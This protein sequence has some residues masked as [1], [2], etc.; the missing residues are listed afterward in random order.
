MNYTKI[1]VID[2]NILSSGRGCRVSYTGFFFV[3]EFM[4][5]EWYQ[6][7]KTTKK[8]DLRL[9]SSKIMSRVLEIVTLKKATFFYGD[10]PWTN[11]K[12]QVKRKQRVRIQMACHQ[13]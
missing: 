2:I 5:S 9:N 10:V 13:L 8:G 1:S 4:P 3:C 11:V 7:T 6:L 12:L